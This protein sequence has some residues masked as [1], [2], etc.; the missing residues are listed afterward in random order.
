MPLCL[1][2][3][4]EFVINKYMK[5]HNLRINNPMKNSATSRKRIETKHKYKNGVPVEKRICKC[6]CGLIF[7]CRITSSK[8]FIWGH[9][10]KNKE[11]IVRESRL[12]L[13]GCNQL[14]ECKKTSNKQFIAYHN[15][16]KK[17]A[18]EK[19]CSICNNMFIVYGYRKY[20]SK[21]CSY[22]CYWKSLKNKV[23]WNKFLTK[24]TDTRVVKNA[25]NTSL[26]ISKYLTDGKDLYL[27]KYSIGTFYSEKNQKSFYYRSKFELLAMQLLESMITVKCYTIN[28]FRILYRYNGGE[29]FY[30]V[31]LYV[32]YTDGQK[33][34]IEV[35]ANWALKDLKTQAKLEAGKR[36]AEENNMRF[37]VWTEDK[38]I[39]KGESYGKNDCK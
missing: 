32:E 39:K 15:R 28:P 19:I 4:K 9:S 23:P 7:E 37:D 22:G 10:N 31:D 21:Y 11:F 14:F 27:K 20:S 35:K 34:L 25:K 5:G 13:C 3:C 2:G 16:R 33:Q 17:I 18:Y 36:F 38:L 26:T 1:C 24:K 8:V 29:H 12:C 30:I 6:G